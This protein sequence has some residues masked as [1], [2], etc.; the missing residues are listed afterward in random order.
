[1]PYLTYDEY[2]NLGF[3]EIEANEF[4]RLLKRASD[5]IDGITIHFYRYNDIENDVPFRREQ[6]KKAIAAQIEYFYEMGATNTHGLQE[7]STVQMGRVMLSVGVKQDNKAPKNDLVS[8]DALFYLR[9]TGLL[10]SALG[11]I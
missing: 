10:H 7:P 8:E 11:V 1:M 4:D 9:D 2:T 5:V 6:F 3:T